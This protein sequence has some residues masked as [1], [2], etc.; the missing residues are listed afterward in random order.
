MKGSLSVRT[1]LVF[2]MLCTVTV[3]LCLLI[4]PAGAEPLSFGS[5]FRVNDQEHQG[6]H[7]AV[8][9][10]SAGDAFFLTVDTNSYIKY[11]TRYATAGGI[12]GNDTPIPVVASDTNNN[13][14]RNELTIDSQDILYILTSIGS[15]P[16]DL[17][18]LIT[19]SDAGDSFSDPVQIHG[20]R[21]SYPMMAVDTHDNDKLYITFYSAYPDPADV[22]L[23]MSTDGGA[24]FNTPVLVNDAPV[25]ASYPG[26]I[27]IGPHGDVFVVWTSR[28]TGNPDEIR[29]ARSTNGGVSFLPSVVVSDDQ[30]LAAKYPRMA[31]DDD[32]I[33]YVVWGDSRN[34]ESDIYLSISTDGGMTF[35]TNLKIND[36]MGSQ[37][38]GQRM[39][40]IVTPESGR[41]IIAYSDWYEDDVLGT[42]GN[43]LVRE[44]LDGGQT[45]GD[46]I[47][48]NDVNYGKPLNPHMDTAGGML[49]ICW[50]DQREDSGGGGRGKRQDT[51]AVG[52]ALASS[53]PPFDPGDCGDMP[54]PCIQVFPLSHGWNL[55][56]I[57]VGLDPLGGDYTASVLAAEIN[58]QAGT[59]I[60]KYVVAWQYDGPLSGEYQEYVVHSGIGE[61]FPVNEGTGYYLYS[62]SPFDME[63]TIVGDCPCAPTFDLV[64]CWNLL[65]WRCMEPMA[66]SAFAAYMDDHIGAPAIQAIVKFVK[67]KGPNGYEETFIAWYPGESDDLFMMTPNEAYWVFSATHREDIPYPC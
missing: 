51:Y 50:Y 12:K 44:S 55:F 45:F 3:V 52:T 28:T 56:S 15:Y 27:V 35:G 65:G 42:V 19:T 32:G 26:D 57:G 30:S 62:T 46:S 43:L 23:T 5:N 49:Y 13:V 1:F 10:D 53:P 11:L 8:A 48:V 37:G 34:D 22:Y 6:R 2:T 60:I 36:A 33:V 41:V 47:M 9:V 21:V 39:P 7:G 29:L 38:A 40:E 14:N 67:V 25:L 54:R 59:E 58:G 20:T 64:E 66:V 24:S 61:D 17:P 16:D 63:F 4:R 31:V 18:H